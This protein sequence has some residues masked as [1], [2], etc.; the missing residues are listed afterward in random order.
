MI[1]FLKQQRL[2][3]EQA[4]AGRNV[5]VCVY[6]KIRVCIDVSTFIVVLH[7]LCAYMLGDFF[8]CTHIK[9]RIVR[10]SLHSHRTA[11]SLALQV[12]M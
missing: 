4:E 9:R 7:G 5:Y 3:L 6:V 1:S 2:W 10:H 11:A 8:I 12:T